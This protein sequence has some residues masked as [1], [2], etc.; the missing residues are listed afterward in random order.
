MKEDEP[1]TFI[2]GKGR[3]CGIRYLWNPQALVIRWCYRG[4]AYLHGIYLRNFTVFVLN[5]H[6]EKLTDVQKSC[7]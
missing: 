5:S 2:R 7:P 4:V 6:S 3:I 1:W